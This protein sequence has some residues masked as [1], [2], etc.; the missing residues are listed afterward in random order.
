MNQ[1]AGGDDF[2]N[3]VRDCLANLYRY[4]FYLVG[5]RQEA[6]DLAQE[7]LLRA[8]RKWHQLRDRERVWPWLCAICHRTFLNRTRRKRL[9]RNL[10]PE[11]LDGHPAKPVAPAELEP[12][13]LAQALADLPP[14]SRLLLV[15][16]YFEGLSYREI[17]ERLGVPVG[18]IMSGLSRAKA[19]LRAKLQNSN[20]PARPAAVV[21]PGGNLP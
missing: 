1:P 17:A 20:R 6:E 5:N 21:S 15:M 13:E 18:T 12:D 4:A 11:I 2:F 19:R 3:N 9:E 7:V 14:R 16:F 8:H 10:P